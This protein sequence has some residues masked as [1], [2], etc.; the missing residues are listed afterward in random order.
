MCA[1]FREKACRIPSY[2]PVSQGRTDDEIGDCAQQKSWPL[3]KHSNIDYYLD[4]RT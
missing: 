2:I 1:F 3:N 4:V